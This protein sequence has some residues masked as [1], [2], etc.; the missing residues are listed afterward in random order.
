METETFILTIAFA[1]IAMVYAAV[2]Q[3]GASGYIASMGLAGFSPLAKRVAVRGAGLSLLVAGGRGA[4]ACWPLLP[5]RRR[6]ADPVGHPDG[7]HRLALWGRAGRER[8]SPATCRSVADGGGDRFR[9][10]HHRNRWRRFPRAGHPCHALGHRTADRGYD[11]GLQPD[12][13]GGCVVG[14]ACRLAAYPG[15]ISRPRCRFGCWRWAQAAFWARLWAVDTC[16]T[17]CCGP[18]WRCCYWCP[19]SG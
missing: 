5:D 13:L 18:C 19:A 14:R 11:G 10:R 17:A 16:P 4:I 15:R 3:A 6:G 2:G 7:P 12:E 9:V 8:Q 1:I